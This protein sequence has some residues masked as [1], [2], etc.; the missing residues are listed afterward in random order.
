MHDWCGVR[1]CIFFR[2]PAVDRQSS[3]HASCIVASASADVFGCFRTRVNIRPAIR[4]DI[5]IAAVIAPE[6]F[7][8]ADQ[9]LGRVDA[10]FLFRQRDSHDDEIDRCLPVAADFKGAGIPADNTVLV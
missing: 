5:E 8:V 1:D 4:A 3:R 7:V 10:A 9:P 2:H 6:T